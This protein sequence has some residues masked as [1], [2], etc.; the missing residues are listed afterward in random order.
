MFAG[1]KQGVENRL[2]EQ[3]NSIRTVENASLHLE[4]KRKFN[5]PGFVHQFAEPE[6]F[7]AVLIRGPQANYSVL[8]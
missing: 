2:P 1:R 7:Y 5:F 6:V 4:L 8:I 3:Q